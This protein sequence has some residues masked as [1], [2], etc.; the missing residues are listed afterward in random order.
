MSKFS[1]DD[2]VDVAERIRQFYAQ[3]PEG[4]LKCGSPP[5]I[6]E[7]GGKPFVMYHAQA[8]RHPDDPLPSDGWAWEPVPGPTQFTKDSELMNAET[9]AW[10]RAIVALGFETKKIASKQEVRNRQGAPTSAGASPAGITPTQ[11][12]EIAQLVPALASLRGVT[13]EEANK[14]IGDV[15]AMSEKDAGAL[16]AKLRRAKANLEG[17]AGEPRAA[18]SGSDDAQGE[19]SGEASS[20][21]AEQS[22]FKA[23]T[24]PRGSKAAA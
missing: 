19:P 14:A 22:P 10:G 9:A 23:P 4:S 5:Q 17:S 18:A 21:P 11:L 1:M 13:V 24:A 8:F 6:V 15:A 2:Y 16:V 12:A 3:H 7:A 20:S